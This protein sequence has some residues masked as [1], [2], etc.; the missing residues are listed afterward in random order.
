MIRVF[1]AQVEH[2]DD[3]SEEEFAYNQGVTLGHAATAKT[4]SGAQASRPQA[5]HL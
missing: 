3:E 4:T 5:I 2:E 1:D